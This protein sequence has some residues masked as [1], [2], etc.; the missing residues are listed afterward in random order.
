MDVTSQKQEANPLDLGTIL[1][2]EVT[3]NVHL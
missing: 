3:G 2:D 1:D